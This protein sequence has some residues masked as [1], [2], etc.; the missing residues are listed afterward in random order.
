MRIKM[1]IFF[2][3]FLLT[4]NAI[5]SQVRFVKA[6]G[7]PSTELPQSIIQTNDNGYVIAGNTASFGAGAIDVFVT[8]FNNLGTSLWTKTVGGLFVDGASSIIQVLDGGFLIA[9]GTNSFGT[10]DTDAFVIKFDTSFQVEW[11]KTVGGSG[12]EIA[13]SVIQTADGGY[14][15]AGET[16]SFGAGEGD[17]LISK[18]DYLGNHLWSK[19]VG[20]DSAE[21][22]HSITPTS[23]GGFAV[24]AYTLGFGVNDWRFFL[25]KFD[26]E[27]NYEWSKVVNTP[28]RARAFWVIQTS[29]NGYAMTGFMAQPSTAYDV[30]FLKFDSSGNLELAKLISEVTYERGQCIVQTQDGGYAIAGGL[31]SIAGMD[32][33]I[34]KYDATG[35]T[36][37]GTDVNAQII[38]PSPVVIPINPTVT[39]PSPQILSPTLT[40]AD[41]S[42][43]SYTLCEYVEIDEVISEIKLPEVIYYTSFFNHEITLHFD[44]FYLFPVEISLYDIS[45]GSICRKRMSYVPYV[46]SL[47]GKK[48]KNLPSGIYFLMIKISDGFTKSLK[49]CKP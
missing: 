10:R 19:T 44:Y 17:I 18:F 39:S 6:L 25:I 8:K 35:N 20:S 48:I 26:S 7:G 9:G 2:L 41:V 11:A 32:M 4:P 37:T 28:F 42:C 27:G 43:Q 5:F 3:S 23:D 38:S 15:I 24:G 30:L 13:H 46:F 33:L 14:V 36:C 1:Q 12:T 29:D 45:G 31:Q 40:V 21:M 16:E 47:R 49:L 22:V 34:V